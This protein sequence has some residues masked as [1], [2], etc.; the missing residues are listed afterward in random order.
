VLP[1][2]RAF[3]VWLV[4]CAAEFVHGALRN[5]YLAPLIGDFR[6]RQVTVFTGSLL[7]LAIAYTM[8]GRLRPYT[9]RHL[10][11]VGLFWLVLT[12]CVDL[13][14]GR[15]TGRSWDDLLAEFEVWNG[16]LFPLGLLFLVFAPLLAVHLRGVP[17]SA[18]RECD[19]SGKGSR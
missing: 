4:I 1:F 18:T 3:L 11:A 16:G 12:L 10:I 5:L 17:V 7:I 9:R 19:Y 2:A 13:A 14:L 15:A 8:S 6:A